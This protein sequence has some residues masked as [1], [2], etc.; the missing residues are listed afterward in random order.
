[1]NTR[2]IKPIIAAWLV[3][4]TSS[5]Q[6]WQ[7]VGTPGGNT[8]ESTSTTPLD[9]F[10]FSPN[11]P[12]VLN[13]Q[14]QNDRVV[15]GG[16]IMITWSENN[17]ELRGFSNTLGEWEILKIAKQDSIIPIVAGDVAAVRIGDSIA[18]FSGVKGWWDVIPL[19]NDSAAQP[20]VSN[21]LVQIENNGHLY[22]FAAAKGRWT[23]PTDTEL[24]SASSELRL[25]NGFKLQQSQR[26]DEWFNSLPR[27]KARGIVFNFPPLLRAHVSIH[28]ARRSWLKEAEDKLNELAAQPEPTTSSEALANS[29]SGSDDAPGLECRIASLREELL[30]LDRD[31]N[32]DAEDADQDAKTREARRQAL[33]KLVEKTFDLRQELQRL[34]AQRMKLRLKSIAENLDARD[35]NREEIIQHRVNEM[36][37]STGRLT[38]RRAGDKTTPSTNSG[39]PATGT[40]IGMP[41]LVAVPD[42]GTVGVAS[43]QPNSDARIQWQQ[44]TEIVKDLRYRSSIVVNML[45]ELKQLQLRVDQWSKAL[46]QLVHRQ[47][48]CAT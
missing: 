24:Q 28:T 46:E 31:V 7:G 16:S 13:K 34:E 12:G 19:S 38:G 3:L 17:D 35:K 21:D 6:A 15:Q 29:S 8:A 42:G 41:G 30:S 25:Q 27:Y 40:P 36:L 11:E 1:M 37:D 47:M 33:R 22:T 2:I 4:A 44:P 23:S 39:M 48:K 20:I 9:P 14:V 5:L 43:H 45:T 10:S 18:A 32:P 26:L